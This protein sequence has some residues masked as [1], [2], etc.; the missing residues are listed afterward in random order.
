[1]SSILMIDEITDIEDGKKI[2][3]SRTLSKDES[4]LADHFPGHPVMPGVLMLETLVQA[5]SWLVRI[6]TDFRFPVAVMSS[7]RSVRY[8]RFV[9]PGDRLDIEVELLS[10]D[11]SRGAF[12]GRGTVDG[13]VAVSGRFELEWF[14]PDGAGD[15]LE[16]ELRERYL[17]LRGKR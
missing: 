3:A 4:Y 16:T 7:A 13:Q 12:R 17:E 1:M 2:Y 10:K 5:A 8:G 9:I 11:G 14:R 6:N 15:S